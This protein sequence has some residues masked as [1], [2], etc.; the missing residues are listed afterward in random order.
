MYICPVLLNCSAVIY[1]LYKTIK[2]YEILK[3][4]V[5]F[6]FRYKLDNIIYFT[7]SEISYLCK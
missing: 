2:V 6:G 4:I 7:F 5:V 1:N 3:F